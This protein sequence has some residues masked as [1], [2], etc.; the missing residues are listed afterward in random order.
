VGPP[1]LAFNV[2]VGSSAT[3]GSV[4]LTAALAI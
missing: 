4:T 2:R 1:L 3:A